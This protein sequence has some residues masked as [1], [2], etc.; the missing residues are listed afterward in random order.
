MYQLGT[1]GHQDKH[2]HLTDFN[3]LSH[4]KRYSIQLPREINHL[5]S[6]IYVM[7][8]LEFLFAKKG[9][10]LQKI[11]L[12]ENQTKLHLFSRSLALTT[13]KHIW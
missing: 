11:R 2:N 12:P 4:G 8:Y 13:R 5:E 6:G 1:K 3:H 9:I 10:E 7:L